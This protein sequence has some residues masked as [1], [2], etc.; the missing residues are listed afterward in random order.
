MTHFNEGMFAHHNGRGN[1]KAAMNQI[2]EAIKK[3]SADIEAIKQKVGVATPVA[4]NAKTNLKISPSE[5]VTALKTEF[6]DIIAEVEAEVNAVITEVE[7]VVA[8]LS[9]DTTPVTVTPTVVA[10]V[11][12][13]T[14]P[15]S[16]K[17]KIK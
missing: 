9:D 4:T 6:D 14:T 16:G 1:V 2:V 17:K 11:T 7:S 12:D 3:M 13:E 10:P 5:V 15:L 8:D